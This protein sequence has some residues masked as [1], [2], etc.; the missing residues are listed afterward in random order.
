MN[1]A[2]TDT[3]SGVDFFDL[4]AEVKGLVLLLTKVNFHVKAL[5]VGASW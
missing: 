4:A 3:V 1:G 2:V 5:R